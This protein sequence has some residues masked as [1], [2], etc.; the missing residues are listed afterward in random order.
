MSCR[1]VYAILSGLLMALHGSLGPAQ[2]PDIKKTEKRFDVQGD[3][4]P[5]GIV[6]R[7]GSAR[8]RHDHVV[9]ALALSPDGKTLASAGDDFTVRFWDPTSGKEIRRFSTESTRV[10]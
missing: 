4:L 10:N 5:A 8:F 6:A 2:A 3:D 7:M 1:S 9:H